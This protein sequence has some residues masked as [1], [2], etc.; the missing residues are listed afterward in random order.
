MPLILLK[1]V[2]RAWRDGSVVHYLFVP[3]VPEQQ[4][5]EHVTEAITLANIWRIRGD[6]PH[7]VAGVG[8]ESRT[9]GSYVQS[10]DTRSVE[11]REDARPLIYVGIGDVSPLVPQTED[12]VLLFFRQVPPRVLP[13]WPEFITELDA[14][15]LTRVDEFLKISTIDPEVCRLLDEIATA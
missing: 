4:T 2:G 13:S 3:D 10:L 15:Q 12:D 1:R 5:N 14:V 7:L 11:G 9:A 6:R 8:D